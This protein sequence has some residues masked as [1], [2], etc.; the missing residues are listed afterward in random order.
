M[1]DLPA[2]EPAI[3]AIVGVGCRLP[4]KAN[5]LDE[6]WSF[7]KRGDSA[8]RSTPT[9]RWDPREFYDPDRERPGKSYVNEAAWLDL[10][11]RSFDPIPFGMTPREAA[12]LDPQQRLLL[13]SAWEAFEDAGIPLARLRGSATSVFVGAFNVDSFVLSTQP[14]NRVLANANT[15]ASVSMTMLSNR[16]SHAFDLRGPSLTLDTACSSSLVAVHYACSSLAS[17]EADLAL[18]GGVNAMLRPELPIILS[19]G[20]FLSPRGQCRTFD[21]G[22]AGYARGEGAGLLLIK[23]LADARRDEDRILALIRGSAVNQDGHTDG[24]SLPSACS[25][26]CT[27]R[28]GSHRAI[29]TTWKRTVRAHQQAIRSRR[30]PS[31]RR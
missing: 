26:A 20:Q 13:E 9:D 15:G 14:H 4:A 27:R 25:N 12:G 22:A 7:L 24:I 28:A 1:G 17:G 23:R 8:I 3:F 21:D 18:A 29:W 11:L 10:D 16:I 2:S 19:K 30:A 31:L 6:F 5:S